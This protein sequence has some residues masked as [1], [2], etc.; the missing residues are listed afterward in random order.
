MSDY[1]RVWDFSTLTGQPILG[2]SVDDE[3][4]AL[5]IAVASKVDES[6]EGAANG[7]ATLGAGTLIPAGI[8]GDATSGGGQLPEASTTALGA[9]EL[10]TSAEAINGTDPL[11]VVTCDALEA[12]LNQNAGYLL[13]IAGLTDPGADRFLIW[14][15]SAGAI[16]HGAFGTDFTVSGTTVSLA[17]TIATQTITTLTTTTTT[18]ATVVLGSLSLTGPAAGR[19]E[20]DGDVVIKHQ[21]STYT[22]GEVYFSDSA[23]VAQGNNGD[24]WFEY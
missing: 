13:D 19:L 9:V 22:S 21:S 7:I 17:A 16:T 14:D 18:A 3:F 5:V 11:R 23:P 4:D 12:V 10:A 6:R 1:S 8:S 15:D 20:V 24:I 2:A